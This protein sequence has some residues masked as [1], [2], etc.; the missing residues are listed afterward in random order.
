MKT[1]KHTPFT[2]KL[3][4]ITIDTGLWAGVYKL[5]GLLPL[6]NA[7][8]SLFPLRMSLACQYELQPVQ[9]AVAS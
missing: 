5:R 3:G 4:S 6:V 1:L 9:S 8:Q 7:H 2:S